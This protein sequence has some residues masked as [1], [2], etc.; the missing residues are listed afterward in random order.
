MQRG[1]VVGLELSD[2][3]PFGSGSGSPGRVAFPA[4]WEARAFALGR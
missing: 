1:I 4:S 3:A 2:L